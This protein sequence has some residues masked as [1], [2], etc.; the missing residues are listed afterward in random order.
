MKNTVELL[1]YYGSDE[2]IA[3][4]A[5]TSTSR[6]LSEE[7]R[8]R[9]PQ[10]IRK[11]WTEGHETPFEKGIVHFLIKSDIATHIHFLKHRMSSLNAE[12]LDGDTLITFENTHGTAVKKKI[13]DI[14]Q[15]W[16][17]GRSHQ[18][19]EKDSQYSKN[20]IRK[21]R[22]RVMN[23][24]TGKLETSTIKNIWKTE[25]K[26]VYKVTL[27]NGRNI[28]CSNN[29]PIF[30]QKDGYKSIS[31]GLAIGDLVACN[32]INIEIENRPW[33]F[34]E[35]FNGAENFTRKD[36]ANKKGI[37]YEL[38]KKWGYIFN[39]TFKEDD[40]KDFKKGMVPWNFGKAGTYS[41]NISENGKRGRAKTVKCGADSHFWR[42]GLS[43]ERVKI[44]AWTTLNAPSVHQKY[45]YTCQKCGINKNLQ[46]HHI[47]PVCQDESRAYDFNNL[48]SVCRKCHF[49][50][51]KSLES[52]MEFARQSL[53]SEV[54]FEYDKRLNRKIG[55]SKM[56][57]YSDII[58]IEHIG[59]KECYDIEV[60]GCFKN[61]VANGIITHNSARYK[62]L[63]EDAIY[64]PDDWNIPLKN[65]LY[66][67]L[68]PDNVER[69]DTW[70]HALMQA[71]IMMNE[72][73]HMAMEELSPVLGR[74][75]TKE[76]ARFFKNYSS[77]ITC[78]VSFNMRS[79]AN[80]I[81][82]RNSEH[83][84]KE[85]RELAQ[86][87]WD[88]VEAIPGNPFQHSLSVIK[89]KIEKNVN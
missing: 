88:L 7:K 22:L 13:K 52:E 61:F 82:L 60:E 70:D 80:F 10:L 12:C 25:E 6:N 39:I 23:E 40:N 2:G 84:Q 67:G 45:N 69:S 19:S 65:S 27:R 32:G 86:Q 33:T 56:V 79:F 41:L 74:K 63:K 42:G 11:L 64:I 47:I 20:R 44:G 17:Y 26:D 31:K 37:K 62:E 59:K 85:I 46:A 50:I 29:H 49:E 35:F 89:E 3:L 30:T 71:S 57:Y 43:N 48:I 21:M 51:H 72:L 76:S 75:R 18:Q 8:K 53:N 16:T 24:K 83:A 15:S 9:I 1:G 66:I 73:Y 77:Q 34:R 5:W 55:S 36:F 38:C 28:T 58:S 68:D 87:M 4:S 14:Y 78:D 81:K 54:V